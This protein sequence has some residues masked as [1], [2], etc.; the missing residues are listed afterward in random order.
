MDYQEV[1]NKLGSLR[2]VQRYAKEKYGIIVSHETIRKN[3]KVKKTDTYSTDEEI[4][5]IRNLYFNEYWSIRQ[6][7]EAGHTYYILNKHIPANERRSWSYRNPDLR[8]VKQCLEEGLE[9]EDIANKTKSIIDKVEKAINFIKN[10][11]SGI[12]QV[13]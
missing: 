12:S 2:K 3:V 9:A 5:H 6:L 10:D 11:N 1:Y 13:S 8:Q 7:V 4:A